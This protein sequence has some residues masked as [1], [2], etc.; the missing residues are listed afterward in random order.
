MKSLS[1]VIVFVTITLAVGLPA[2]AGLVINPTYNDASFTAAG[3]SAAAVHNA[4]NFV[5]NEYQNLFT[6]NVHVNINVVAGTT[7]L[8]QSNT[9]LLGFLTYAQTRSALLAD[10]AANP[11]ATRATAGPSLLLVI[12]YFNSLHVD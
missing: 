3:Y 5:A 1:S 6:D 11:D 4:F 10:Y 12:C 8:G 9:N 2:S 7:G